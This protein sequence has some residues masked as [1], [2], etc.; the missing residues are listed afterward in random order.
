MVNPGEDTL[1]PKAMTEAFIGEGV[2]VNSGNFNGMDNGQAKD[3]I[4]A[5]LEKEG[6]GKKTVSFRLRDWG[7]SRQRVHALIQKA[8]H[9]EGVSTTE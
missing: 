4:A 3:E 7:I 5:Y 2:M 8:L 9:A 6:L 1:D